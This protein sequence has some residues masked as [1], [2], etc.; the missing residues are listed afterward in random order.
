MKSEKI[1]YLDIADCIVKLN[2]KKT[3]WTLVESNF[4]KQIEQY[5]GGFVCKNVNKTPYFT[6]NFIPKKHADLI[7][8]KKEKKAYISYYDQIS[9]R[10]INT[11][12]QISLFQFQLILGHI[13]KKYLPLHHGLFLHSSAAL[14]NK[15]A[16][17]F[18]GP[19]G[20]G[21]STSIKLLRDVFPIISDDST[22]IK[23]KGSTYYAYQ[24]PF[25]EKEW[26]VQKKAGKHI[27]NRI[28]I[29]KKEDKCF[30]EM[31]PD[32]NTIF[33][34]IYAQV[35]KD[36]A[37]KKSDEYVLQFASLFEGFR[38]MHFLKE[39]KKVVAMLRSDNQI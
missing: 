36:T 22:I 29:L 32:I 35:W 20:A 2:F 9:D 15:R 39:S 25:Y 37:A 6:V 19:P 33:K 16:V 5:Y 17:L 23:K 14:I 4:K 34:L 3:E 18:V 13:L 27:L 11:S 7:F 24:T 28:Y 21:K 30:I 8:D 1:Y 38:Y 31:V 12:Y 10:E 26:W